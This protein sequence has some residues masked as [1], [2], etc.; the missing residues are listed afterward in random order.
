[1][2][3]KTARVLTKAIRFLSYI[4]FVLCLIEIICGNT[5]AANG[6]IT[7]LYIGFEAGMCFLLK[8]TDNKESD[9]K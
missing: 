1:M 9:G 3:D 6:L 2:S 5:G 4:G 8:V 7:G